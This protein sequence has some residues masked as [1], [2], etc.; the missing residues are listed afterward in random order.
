MELLIA[1]PLEKKG[2]EQHLK[3]EGNWQQLHGPARAC[4]QAIGTWRQGGMFPRDPAP[5]HV[6]G[7]GRGVA[8]T[9]YQLARVCA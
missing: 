4:K 3:R 8:G 1:F 5:G 7:P 9:G 2:D 6:G